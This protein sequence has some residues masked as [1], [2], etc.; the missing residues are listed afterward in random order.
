M[1][2]WEQ[3]GF[4]AYPTHSM[5][6]NEFVRTPGDFCIAQAIMGEKRDDPI[7]NNHRVECAERGFKT[8]AITHSSMR[9]FLCGGRLP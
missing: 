7:S 1:S 2:R 9:A 4:T 8:D 5:R 3:D 6:E